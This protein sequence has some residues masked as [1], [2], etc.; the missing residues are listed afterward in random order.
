[1]TTAYAQFS[2]IVIG[3]YALDQRITGLTSIVVLNHATRSVAC[4]V[5]RWKYLLHD[6]NILK[7]KKAMYSR[8]K[9][10]FSLRYVVPL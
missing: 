5:T 6:Q 2:V 1:M 3:G 4:S 10:A 8:G 9:L 7:N